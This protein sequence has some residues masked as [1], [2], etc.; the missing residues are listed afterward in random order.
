MRTTRNVTL[1]LLLLA[2]TAYAADEIHF[3]VT[4]PTSVAVDWRGA[5]AELRYGPTIAYGQTA[6]GGAPSHLPYSSSGPWREAKISGLSPGATYHYAIGPGS[7]H[8]FKTPPM[9]GRSGFTVMVQGDIGSA[10]KYPRVAA[11][12][13]LI[14]GQRP[15]LVLC[16]GDLTYGNA[17][18]Q[19]A[20][21]NH[22][23]DVMAWSQD[24]AYMPAH[25][26]HEW[27][28]AGDNML[29]YKGRFDLPNPQTSPGSPTISCCGED[30]YW[31]DYGNVRFIAYPEPWSG[32][33]ADWNTK[34]RVLMAEA[35]A[36]PLI[37]FI[38][39]FG[40]RPAYSS[41][42]HPGSSTLA[43]YMNA[44]GASFQK[45]ELNLNGHS[46]N[47]E[48]TN[49]QAGV[50]HV[51]VGTGGSTLEQDGTCLWLG[52]CPPPAYTAFRAMRHGALRIRVE[53]NSM[54]GE[55]L[56]GP[57][58]DTG[59][60][61]NDVTCV[62][63]EVLDR[64]AFGSTAP[65]PPPDPTPVPPPAPAPVDTTNLCANPSFEAST[66]GWAGYHGAT[67]VRTVVAGAVHG[68][69]V[70]SVIGPATVIDFG[71]DDSP[72]VVRSTVAG[73]SYTFSAWV[74]ADASTAKADLQLREYAG[75]TKVGS[76]IVAP[77]VNLSP[78]WQRL[79]GTIT[80]GRAGSSIDFQVRVTP[81]R[82]SEAFQVD[83]VTVVTNVTVPPPVPPP[84]P[85]PSPPPATLTG[86]ITM[87][88]FEVA[89][90]NLG[91][92]SAVQAAT[93]NS[94][95]VTRHWRWV[96]GAAA[97]EDSLAGRIPDAA[98]EQRIGP[99]PVGVY[100]L[101][102][103]WSNSAGPGCRKGRTFVVRSASAPPLPPAI[104]DLQVR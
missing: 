45:Y 63:G 46:H 68:A 94:S 103:W 26:N 13:S 102:W 76:T 60:N 62:P 55:F 20:V 70:A 44:M 31:F 80:A 90:G 22:F 43:G 92:C 77:A 17:H 19:A 41:G 65:V 6:F 100:T 24:A 38:V 23:N 32:A 51:T 27:D 5:E 11:V 91:S 97:G 9:P 37:D 3:T 78:T 34:A 86:Y 67:V 81:T 48:R 39:T 30:W 88:G 49:P 64:F 99:V 54:V 71:L 47:Y 14:A 101:E 73:S 56:C 4:G 8:T 53:D 84:T 33:W 2:A 75:S 15:E 10:A 29:N 95:T 16:V 104:N 79:A 98:F 96:G 69:A 12:Q 50:T 58:G 66:T 7:D 21:D 28:S 40:H 52:G 42:H 1:A 25:G 59:S 83:G 87:S 61:K 57:A 85:P 36:D 74:R 35:Q 93:L 82:A 72:A 89:A 18:G